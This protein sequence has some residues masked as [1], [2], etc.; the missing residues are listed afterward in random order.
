[1]MTAGQTG[2][3]KKVSQKRDIITKTKSKFQKMRKILIDKMLNILI[4]Y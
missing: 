1:M 2:E 3:N 4:Y